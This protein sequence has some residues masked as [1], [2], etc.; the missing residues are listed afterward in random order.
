MCYSSIM[1]EWQQI[2]HRD[3]PVNLYIEGAPTEVVPLV[4]DTPRMFGLGVELPD[5]SI[6]AGGNLSPRDLF[7]AWRGTKMLASYEGL[8]LPS[9]NTLYHMGSRIPVMGMHLDDAPDV[10]SVVGA[11]RFD[12]IMEAQIPRRLVDL[13]LDLQGQQDAPSLF[14]VTYEVKAGAMAWQD[15]FKDFGIDHP[16][17]VERREFEKMGFVEA[18]RTVL[19]S[20]AVSM[21]LIPG[22][23]GYEMLE[24]AIAMRLHDKSLEGVDV[25]TR[26]AIGMLDADLGL[27]FLGLVERK[28]GVTL[29]GNSGDDAKFDEAD[30]RAMRDAARWKVAHT[31]DCV[32]GGSGYNDAVNSAALE[33][34][35]LQMNAEAQRLKHHEE[36]EE[37]YSRLEPRIRPQ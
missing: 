29:G 25:H 16:D 30:C 20:A 17:E 15:R 12:R 6:K 37:R 28:E 34:T 31:T 26:V 21:G 10:M 1:A 23:A 11:D 3:E 18:N 24:G 32:P 36:A 8:V 4:Y 5:G 22:T 7:A 33:L 14:P 13:A 19:E 9:L 27:T 35:A 2:H